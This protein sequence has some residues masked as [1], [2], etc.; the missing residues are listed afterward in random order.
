MISKDYLSLFWGGAS[1]ATSFDCSGFVSWVINH[2]GWNYGRLTAQGLFNVT[3]PVTAAN[4]KPGDLVFF[5]GTYNTTEVSHVG[6]YVGNQKMLHCGDPISYANL[7]E[8]Y[9]QQHLF[10]YGRLARN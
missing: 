2:S 1:P 8:N 7:N 6:I 10:C 5:K 9:W 4:A 3:T